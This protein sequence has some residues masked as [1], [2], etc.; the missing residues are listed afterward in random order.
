MFYHYS[1][2]YCSRLLTG[3]LLLLMACTQPPLPQFD[4]LINNEDYPDTRQMAG[5]PE[6]PIPSVA[7]ELDASEPVMLS[8]GLEPNQGYEIQWFVDGMEYP[9]AADQPNLNLELRA[10]G[11]HQVKVCISRT[12]QTRC[13]EK[14]LFIIAHSEEEPANALPSET[15]GIQEPVA[16]VKEADPLV[17]APP[18]EN[19]RDSEE[20]PT[21]VKP[22]EPEGKPNRK[23][24][25]AAPPVKELPPPS[26]REYNEVGQIGARAALYNENCGV[27]SNNEVKVKLAPKKHVILSRFSVQSTSCG[28]LEVKVTGEGLSWQNT[29][30]L[31]PGRN[32]ISLIGISKELSPGNSYTM[33]VAPRPSNKCPKGSAAPALGDARNCKREI[34]TTNGELQLVYEEGAITI[35]DLVYNYAE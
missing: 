28:L 18:V 6:S 9:E 13:Q 26:V 2:N 30:T 8:T 32:T 35:F 7:P 11:R 34:D 21:G 31:T 33:T 29:Q 22:V 16:P 24:T 25:S 15:P 12:E 5:L 19:E 10:A 14:F 1:K 23:D 3:L 4:L 20:E 27:S 17:D